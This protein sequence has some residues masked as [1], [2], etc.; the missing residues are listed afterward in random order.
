MKPALLIASCMLLLAGCAHLEVPSR[1]IYPFRAEFN[2]AGVLDGVDMRM[3]GA[4]YLTSQGAGIIQVYGPG[5]MALYTVDIDGANLA[6]KDM[7]G[8]KTDDI[9]LP[10]S[11]LAGLLAG[12]VPRGTY[13]YRE[14]TLDGSRVI[15]P[16]GVL[17]IDEETRP[18]E[19]HVRRDPPIDLIFRHEGTNVT[20]DTSHG[21]DNFTITLMVNEGGRWLSP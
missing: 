2:G 9:S 17:I 19:I 12:D 5:G 11:D 14:K 8:K 15:Y 16:W 3:T 4:L 18:R 21:P 6:L 20:I 1:N 10:M 7:W 13:L